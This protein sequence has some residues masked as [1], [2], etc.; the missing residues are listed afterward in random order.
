MGAAPDVDHDQA[1]RGLSTASDPAVDDRVYQ[2][3]LENLLACAC[4][5]PGGLMRLKGRIV[6][7]LRTVQAR[8]WNMLESLPPQYW[9]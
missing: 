7:G 6:S 5:P 1:E 4:Q 3:A 9:I 2:A 8:L